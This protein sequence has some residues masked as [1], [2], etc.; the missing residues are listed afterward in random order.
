MLDASI[1]TTPKVDSHCH[2]LDPQGFAYGPD[3]AYRPAGQETGS[4]DYF[5][6]VL[7][8]IARGKGRFKGIT[9]RCCSCL[10]FL[11]PEIGLKSPSNINSLLFC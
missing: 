11:E 4:A 10:G 5:E 2:I 8:T 7:D 9:C 1:Y 3:V 6:H